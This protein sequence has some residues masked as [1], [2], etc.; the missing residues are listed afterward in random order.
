[1]SLR[2]VRRKV[3][4]AKFCQD[5]DDSTNNSDGELIIQGYL[6]Y[7]H[8]LTCIKTHVHVSYSLYLT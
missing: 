6:I 5:E 8:T 4:Y 2:R 1:M 3:D 7:K